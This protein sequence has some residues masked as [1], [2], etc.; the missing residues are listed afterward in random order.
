[1]E[2]IKNHNLGPE[3]IDKINCNIWKFFKF[4]DNPGIK[5]SSN[6]EFYKTTT[7]RNENQQKLKN[8]VLIKTIDGMEHLAHIIHWVESESNG[9]GCIS[10]DP[11][12]DSQDNEKT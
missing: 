8:K 6:K 1:M 11:F 10:F 12:W 5:D 9:W 7:F 2:T 3:L 4:K